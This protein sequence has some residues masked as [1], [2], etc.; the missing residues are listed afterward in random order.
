MSAGVGWPWM[1][2]QPVDVSNRLQ[3]Q[4]I[5]PVHDFDHRPTLVDLLA[6]HRQSLN[7]MTAALAVHPLYQC[8]KHDDVWMVRFV[9]SHPKNT[10]AAITAAE[11][12]LHF[13]AQHELDA[14]DIRHCPIGPNV[15]NESIQRF[16][17]YCKSDALSF[18][19]PD[20][21]L[22]L[23]C[24]IDL[25]RIDQ[26]ALV[27]NVPESDWLPFFMYVL[28]FTHQWNDFLSRTTGR[29]TRSVRIVDASSL[30]LKT[31]SAEN[32][33]RDDRAWKA[34]EAFYPQLL[35][36]Q[37]VCHAPAW[38]QVPWRFLRPCLPQRLVAQADFV[39]PKKNAKDRRRLL[40]YISLENLPVRFGGECPV[41]PLSLSSR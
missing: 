22:G 11:R 3:P 2:E 15:P 40:I 9:L 26:H 19:I 30:S 12:T 27:Q 1:G 36:R 4:P 20:D 41:W 8:H 32:S 28:E 38:I 13:R 14:T 23:V 6:Q 17:L 35:D 34:T 10:T 25:A 39:A 16:Y 29:F 31:W 24:F 18:V 33:K 7:Q 37:F 5:P 21:R